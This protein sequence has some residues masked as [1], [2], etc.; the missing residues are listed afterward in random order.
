MRHPGHRLL[1]N[2]G[3]L[4]SSKL[5]QCADKIGLSQ[6]ERIAAPKMSPD[7]AITNTAVKLPCEPYIALN[8][9][10]MSGIPYLTELRQ[11]TA[12]IDIFW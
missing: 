3:M 11:Y 12:R 1:K 5:S 8:F 4:F 6:L 10:K 9:R 7:T 2:N